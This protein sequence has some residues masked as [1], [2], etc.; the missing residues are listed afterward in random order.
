MHKLGEI[1]MLVCRINDAEEI[2]LNHLHCTR[3][4]LDIFYIPLR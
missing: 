1:H 4:H 2:P 3:I